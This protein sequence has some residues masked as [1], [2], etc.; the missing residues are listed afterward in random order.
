M[1]CS[2]EN[3][4]QPTSETHENI[5]PDY[6]ASQPTIAVF[7]REK[8]FRALDR[9]TTVVGQSTPTSHKYLLPS[10]FLAKI[11]Y[12]ILITPLHTARSCHSHNTVELGYNVIKG[13]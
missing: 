11:Q 1:P 3:I 12:A 5:S 7:E 8:T 4:Y 13:T 9:V 10:H 2:Q 6:T